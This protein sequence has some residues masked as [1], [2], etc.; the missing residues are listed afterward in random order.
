[1]QNYLITQTNYFFDPHGTPD[2]GGTIKFISNN[3]NW[4]KINQKLYY[5]NEEIPEPDEQEIKE[6]MKENGNNGDDLYGEDGYN[7]ERVKYSVKIINKLN[8]KKYQKIIEDYN[9]L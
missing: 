4:G 7:C 6:W 8:S 3:P 9:N 2:E 5:C 1:M